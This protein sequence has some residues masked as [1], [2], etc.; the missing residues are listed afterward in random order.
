MIWLFI[1]ILCFVWIIVWTIIHAKI[2]AESIRYRC[3][4]R[5]APLWTIFV[6]AIIFA[7]SMALFINQYL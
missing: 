3:A 6:P 5:G 1:S 7:I 2:F 4:V